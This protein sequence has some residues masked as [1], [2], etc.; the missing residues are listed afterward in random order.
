MGLETGT[1][2]EDLVDT[3]P[4]NADSQTQ[5]D[6][7]LRLIKAVLLN[8]FPNL[9][10]EAMTATAA[11]LNSVTA[12]SVPSGLIAMWSGS[13]AAVPSGWFLCDGGNGT[14]D[15]GDRFVVGTITD[16][17]GANYDV[18][19]TGGADSHSHTAQS[20]AITIANMPAHTHKAAA[21]GAGT[22]SLSSTNQ[23]GEDVDTGSSGQDYTLK[24]T[25]TPATLALTSSTGSGT[26]HTHVIE[27][28]DTV[29]P[30]YALAYI[31]KS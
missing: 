13:V 16:A 1:F 27:S 8:Q 4:N 12:A 10:A 24:G 19:D 18:G 30:F 5:G 29:P 26:G 3:N 23:I 2:I 6:D 22:L 7:H 28:E 9:G 11:Q 25:N 20:T 17:G 31:M 21:S 14:P 15:L